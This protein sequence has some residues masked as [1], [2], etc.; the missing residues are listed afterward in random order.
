MV[1]RDPGYSL[2]EWSLLPESE[3]LVGSEEEGWGSGLEI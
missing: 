3:L 1:L 2:Q